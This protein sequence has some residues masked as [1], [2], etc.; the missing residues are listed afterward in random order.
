MKRSS[1]K[2]F[3]PFFIEWQHPFSPKSGVYDTKEN[4]KVFND[5]KSFQDAKK[6]AESMNKGVS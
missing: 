2:R 4:K 5:L 1:N 6:K 3:I